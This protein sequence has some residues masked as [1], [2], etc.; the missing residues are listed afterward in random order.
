M[1]FF[2]RLMEYVTVL[3]TTMNKNVVKAEIVHGFRK[4]IK[5]LMIFK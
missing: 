3:L 5:V 1:L 2:F 4:T